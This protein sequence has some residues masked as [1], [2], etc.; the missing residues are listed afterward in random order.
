MYVFRIRHN[1]HKRKQDA[2][3]NSYG[4]DGRINPPT[5]ASNKLGQKW[6][7]IRTPSTKFNDAR[8]MAKTI[9]EIS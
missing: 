9:G 3:I 5:V 6:C 7:V 1:F 2:R 8:S 4:L